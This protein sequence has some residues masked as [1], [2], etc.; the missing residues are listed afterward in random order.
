MIDRMNY[1]PGDPGYHNHTPSGICPLCDITNSEN[2]DLKIQLE[3]C[4]GMIVQQLELLKD[5][6]QAADAA[7]TYL[8][9]FGF[10]EDDLNL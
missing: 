4:Q 8:E 7:N 6:R 9:E 10:S 3:L 2:L 1:E 5:L